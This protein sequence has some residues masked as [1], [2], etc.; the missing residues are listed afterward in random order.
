[1]SLTPE[2][3]KRTRI[4]VRCC[5]LQTTVAPYNKFT[6]ACGRVYLGAARDE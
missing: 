4:E 2:D 5:N 6:C 3:V 1:M